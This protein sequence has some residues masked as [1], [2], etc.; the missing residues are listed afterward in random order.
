MKQKVAPLNNTPNKMNIMIGWSAMVSA[1]ATVGIM[2]LTI[3][4]YLIYRKTI[5]QQKKTDD[6]INALI[7]AT[8][9]NRKENFTDVKMLFEKLY[10]G[11]TRVF[12]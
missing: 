5:E 2:F 4:N 6:L 12:K 9:M 3:M 10:P 7:V 11:K 8:L 1:I